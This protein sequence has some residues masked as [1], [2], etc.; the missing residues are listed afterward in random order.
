MDWMPRRN[1]AVA[2]LSTLLALGMTGCSGSADQGQATPADSKNAPT[3]TPSPAFVPGEGS[4]QWRTIDGDGFTIALPADF[5]EGSGKAADGA[6]LYIFEAPR[7]DSKDVDIVRL[8]VT[9]EKEPKNDLYAQ[10]A[11][12]YTD[13]LMRD[14]EAT[15]DLVTWPGGDQS[16]LMKWRDAV[17][18]DAKS[19]R[20][21]WQLS[22]EASSK[23]QYS[24]IAFAPEA[25][26]A[27]EQLPEI[28][29]SFKVK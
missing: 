7:Q 18:G 15:R 10:S 21:F 9:V 12:A 22:V 2:A 17:G 23:A 28:L 24:V 11:V 1:V 14:P 4:S 5:R 20:Q 16:V 29:Q 19:K 6:P 13:K 26:F 3:S 25:K 27:S 8:A